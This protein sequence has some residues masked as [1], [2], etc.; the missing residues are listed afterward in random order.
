MG[1]GEEGGGASRSRHHADPNTKDGKPKGVSTSSLARDVAVGL[2]LATAVY[3]AVRN[4]PPIIGD[5][6][7]GLF[8]FEATRESPLDRRPTR[9]SQ[10]TARRVRSD[11]R[12]RRTSM[13]GTTIDAARMVHGGVQRR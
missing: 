12:R 7:A 6:D 2:V 4:E 3:L 10:P 1:E 9:T 11:S 5:V 8:W 13:I